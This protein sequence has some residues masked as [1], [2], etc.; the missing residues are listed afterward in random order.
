M[1]EIIP[2]PKLK[3]QLITSINQAI[4]NGQFDEAYQTFEL[5][6]Q[7]FAM[8]EELSLKKCEVLKECG[9]YLELR[10]E[11]SILLNQGHDYYDKIVVYFVESLYYLEQ[12]QTVVEIIN[13]I[14]DE[15]IEHSTRMSLLPI[16]DM[17]KDKLD[18]RQLK[19]SEV[20]R[21][22]QE[23]QF[24]EQINLLIDLIDNHLGVFNLTL[25]QIIENESLHP[26]VQSLILEYL[27]LGEWSA[28]VKFE[29][30][31]EIITV[32]PIE[33]DGI[34]RTNINK[35]IIPKIIDQLEIDSPSSIE[36]AKS[37]LN[38]HA[39]V[40]YPITFSEIKDE[41]LIACYLKLLSERFNIDANYKSVNQDDW[42][43]F[44]DFIQKL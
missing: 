35:N 44:I 28:D 20:L 27:R 38:Q 21:T 7:H 6:E 25:A 29:K 26:N 2:F 12:Y 11:A 33:L 8:D 18:Q 39:I 17:A 1:S 4:K 40:M 24:E 19:A 36:L 42:Q 23:T 37:L 3:N 43:K 30:L 22:F 31:N 5:Y 32:N 14:K 41:N 15:N 13:Q 16:Q 9:H 10:E 34:E